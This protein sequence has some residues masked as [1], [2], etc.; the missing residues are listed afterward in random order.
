MSFSATLV[1]HSRISSGFGS[2]WVVRE[3]FAATNWCR[4]C[5]MHSALNSHMTISSSNGRRRVCFVRV[6]LVGILP[7]QPLGNSLADL[8]NG[9]RRHITTTELPGQGYDDNPSG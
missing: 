7:D 4:V 5:K 1:A 6:V 3:G 2:D 8:R 9:M